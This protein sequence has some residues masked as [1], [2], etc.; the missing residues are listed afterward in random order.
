M[1]DSNDRTGFSPAGTIGVDSV[2]DDFAFENRTSSDQWGSLRI[3]VF[4][5]T[6][7]PHDPNPALPTEYP[8]YD[9]LLPGN[10]E[11]HGPEYD[12]D[13]PRP[14]PGRDDDDPRDDDRL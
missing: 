9:P 4:P 10:V 6:R 3:T 1:L 12:P 2:P 7:E 13:E 8:H 11:P 14:R 5:P